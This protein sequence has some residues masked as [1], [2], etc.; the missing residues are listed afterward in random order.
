MQGKWVSVT[1]LS[2][3]VASI[4]SISLSEVFFG[5]APPT[6]AFRLLEASNIAFEEPSLRAFFVG[7]LCFHTSVHCFFLVMSWPVLVTSRNS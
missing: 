5:L 3:V 2:G 6:V 7:F 4:F 1:I